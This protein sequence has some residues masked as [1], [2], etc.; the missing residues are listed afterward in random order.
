MKKL[1]LISALLLS[2]NSWGTCYYPKMSFS[3][4]DGGR[5]ITIDMVLAQSSFKA[6]Q[7]EME[8]YL[9]CLDDEL[10][11]VPK[12]LDDYDEIRSLSDNKYNA[13][14]D[15]LKT[16]AEKWNQTVRAYK[17]ESKQSS[18]RM[19]YDRCASEA[20]NKA[21]SANEYDEHIEA[22]RLLDKANK[23]TSRVAKKSPT[24]PQ[25]NLP[26]EWE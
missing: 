2:F 14:V 13:A 1:I 7:A 16:M 3:I 8:A 5:A 12:S 19:T 11:K 21:R 23:S 20:A 24:Q 26:K 25:E 18:P 9:E 6:Y 4:P 15:E 17:G 10:A 22:C